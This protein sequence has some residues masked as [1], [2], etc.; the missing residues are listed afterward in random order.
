MTIPPHRDLFDK[1]P[2]STLPDLTTESSIRL[3]PGARPLP[4][5]RHTRTTA[6]TTCNKDSFLVNLEPDPGWQLLYSGPLRKEWSTM[7]AKF[8]D[9]VSGYPGGPTKVVKPK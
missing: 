7:K 8:A 1:T 5:L 4:A 6:L 9:E 2:V 3:L